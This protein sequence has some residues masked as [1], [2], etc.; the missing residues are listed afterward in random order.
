[1]FTG[2]GGGFIN[3]GPPFTPTDS[4]ALKTAVTACLK[5]TADGSGPKFSLL[6]NSAT[7]FPNR[8]MGEWDISSVTDLSSSKY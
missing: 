7:G 4:G 5:E 8:V 2:D 1:M 3:C 6:I